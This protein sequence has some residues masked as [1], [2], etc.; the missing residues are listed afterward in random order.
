MSGA[1]ARGD[2]VLVRLDPAEGREIRKTRPAV[3][4]SNAAACRFDAVLQVVPVTALPERPLRPYEA[5]LESADSG[6]AKPSRAVANQIRTVTRQRVVDRLGTLTPAE[7]E[8]VERAV[9]IQ[10]GMWHAP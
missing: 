9:Q 2:V 4:L 7:L 3:V 6:L 5:A 10:L 8:A 1:V